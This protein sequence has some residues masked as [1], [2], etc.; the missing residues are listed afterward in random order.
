MK[1][2][3]QFRTGATYDT[4]KC[5]QIKRPMDKTQLK[6]FDIKKALAGDPVV[7]QSGIK[8]IQIAHFPES[9][10]GTGEIAVLLEGED[11]IRT[12]KPD[13]DFSGV[14]HLMPYTLFMAPKVRTVWVNLHH[15]GTS[16]PENLVGFSS[17][18]NG[19]DTEDEADS[20][21]KG[22]RLGNRAYPIEITEE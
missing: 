4:S 10:Y 7:T 14:G 9:N 1:D 18:Y 5:N 11:R 16:L 12:Y 22:S 13:G 3:I 6:P 20:C 17:T 2:K 19:Y 15:N 21:A 8:V